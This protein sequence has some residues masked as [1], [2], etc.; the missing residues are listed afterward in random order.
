MNQSCKVTKGVSYLLKDNLGRNVG[1][2]DGGSLDSSAVAGADIISSLDLDL[3][4]YG[5]TLMQGKT[6]SIVA[7]EPSTGEVLTMISSPSYDPKYPKF[8]PR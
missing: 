1:A 8:R 2:F 5:E 3:Q 4:A 6:G 7:L